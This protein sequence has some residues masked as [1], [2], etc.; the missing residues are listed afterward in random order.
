ME[1]GAETSCRLE[2][3]E[4]IS[5]VDAFRGCPVMGSKLYSV[6][7][8]I[9]GKAG[10]QLV[11]EDKRR[12]WGLRESRVVGATGLK[13]CDDDAGT[14]ATTTRAMEHTAGWCRPSGNESFPQGGSLT[15]GVCRRDERGPKG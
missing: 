1:V 12:A 4:R 10:G 5:G 3:R 13:G 14:H 6:G 7:G 8:P 11:L 15:P 2:D 9:T